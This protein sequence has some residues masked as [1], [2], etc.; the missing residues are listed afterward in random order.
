MKWEDALWDELNTMTP[1]EQFVALGTWISYITQHL[2][3]QLGNKRRLAVVQ[4]VDK[5]DIDAVTFAE[6]VGS[7]PSAVKR[8]LDEGRAL[9]RREAGPAETC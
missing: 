5:G 6:R 3:T 1:D 7:G 4:A 9:A 2:L 8:L